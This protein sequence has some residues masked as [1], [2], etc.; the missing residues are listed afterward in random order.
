MR[1]LLAW[2]PL[3]RAARRAP[4]LRC[5]VLRGNEEF[6]GCRLMGRKQTVEGRGGH[7]SLYGVG[8]AAAT[9]EPCRRRRRIRGSAEVSVIA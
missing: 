1:D 3:P 6:V 4:S 8:V 5:D 2:S 7:I 9:L